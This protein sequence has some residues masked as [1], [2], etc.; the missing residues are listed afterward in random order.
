MS[1]TADTRT[2]DEILMALALTARDMPRK[3]RRLMTGKARRVIERYTDDWN[4]QHDLMTEWEEF[5]YG[6]PR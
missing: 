5:V 1:M 4:L 2:R 3:A 6:P